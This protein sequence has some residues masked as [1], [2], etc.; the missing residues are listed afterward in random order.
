MFETHPHFHRYSNDSSEI[1]LWKYM[2]FFKFMYLLRNE[3]LFFLRTDK[4]SDKYEGFM[5]KLRAEDFNSPVTP[6]VLTRMDEMY[7]KV[8]QF[9]FVNCW[10]ESNFENMLMWDNY[11]DAMGGIAIK[12]TLEK[13]QNSIKDERTVYGSPIV[14]G[15]EPERGN[16]FSP[17]IYKKEWFM[18]ENEY[19][20][21]VVDN[22]FHNPQ[23]TCLDSAD[24]SREISI[25]TDILVDELY[26]HPKTEEWVKTTCRELVEQVNPKMEILNSLILLS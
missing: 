25:S 17:I 20:L 12:T 9:T 26:F 23:K 18:G 4:F 14:Y 3:K 8:K 16:S 15:K 1:I 22:G 19:R 5:R 6:V 10:H 13:L 24:V 2:D 21:F 11:S 7:E